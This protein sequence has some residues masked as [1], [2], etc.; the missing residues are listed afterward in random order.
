MIS[1]FLNYCTSHITLEGN[2]TVLK[3]LCGHVN[4]RALRASHA[5]VTPRG[6]GLPGLWARCPVCL[7]SRTK[8]GVSGQ[9]GFG[10]EEVLLI[11]SLL[12]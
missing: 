2:S 11:L 6:G 7:Y 8:S 1:Q 3:L 5:C 9:P 4:V 12:K 10:A